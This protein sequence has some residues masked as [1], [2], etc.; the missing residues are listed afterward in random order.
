MGAFICG[1]ITVLLL[2]YLAFFKN[3]KQKEQDIYANL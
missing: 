1:G 2:G 3:N